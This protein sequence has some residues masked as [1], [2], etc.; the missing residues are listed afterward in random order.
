MLALKR[1]WF[2]VAIGGVA[3]LEPIMLLNASRHPAGFA[4]VVLGVQALGA[5]VA[6]ALA[7]G[8]GRPKPN[9]ATAVNPELA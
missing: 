6:L 2:L 1:T 7:L 9:P 4:G 3:V 8:I 5:V